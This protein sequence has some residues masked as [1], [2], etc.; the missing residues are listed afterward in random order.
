MKTTKDRV[1]AAGIAAL[2][3]VAFLGWVWQPQAVDRVTDDLPRATFQAPAPAAEQSAV[4]ASPGTAVAAPAPVT[5][6]DV[7]EYSVAS[8]PVQPRRTPKAVRKAAPAVRERSQPATV[9]SRIGVDARHAEG[10]RAEAVVPAPVETVREHVTPEAPRADRAEAPRV[11]ETPHATA[12]ERELRA[13]NRNADRHDVRPAVVVRQPRRS[14]KKSAMIIGGGAAAGAV[15]GAASGGGRGAAIGAAAG[16][17]GGWIYDRLTKR[18]RDTTLD[19]GGIYRESASA[20]RSG[21]L[22]PY[23]GSY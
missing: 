13:D 18:K 16:G 1:T 20:R 2:A 11:H 21:E 8:E 4:P 15:I 10:P 6:P 19:N 9:K 14:G 17:V 5:T 23:R 22:D 12:E 7:P 3:G